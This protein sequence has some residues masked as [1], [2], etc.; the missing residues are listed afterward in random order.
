[1]Y[2]IELLANETLFLQ[3]SRS[4]Q[5]LVFLPLMGKYQNESPMFHLL[6]NTMDTTSSVDNIKTL[7]R[8]HKSL[9]TKS[10]H[11]SV[12][13]CAALLSSVKVEALSFSLKWLRK[14]YNNKFFE[15]FSFPSKYVLKLL[16]GDIARITAAQIISSEYTNFFPFNIWYDR[17]E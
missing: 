8:K 12:F 9:M 13:C 3:G 11:V 10:K 14:I 6:L 1:M 5:K 17:L 4:T 2:S 16:L 15:R 7:S